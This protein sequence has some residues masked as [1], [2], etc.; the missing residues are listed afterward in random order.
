MICWL[1]EA[2]VFLAAALLGLVNDWHIL[3]FLMESHSRN[4]TPLLNTVTNHSQPV[5][6]LKILETFFALG[7]LGLPARFSS[8]LL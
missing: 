4:I 5:H 7:P 3:R 1:D 2:H 6:F 8:V